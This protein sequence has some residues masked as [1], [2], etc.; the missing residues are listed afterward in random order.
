MPKQVLEN[1]KD[2]KNKDSSLQHP[3]WL[4]QPS[5]SLESKKRFISRHTGEAHNSAENSLTRDVLN[6]THLESGP[7]TQKKASQ[8]KSG[9]QRLAKQ[10]M[11]L[12]QAKYHG[13]LLSQVPRVIENTWVNSTN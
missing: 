5:G 9:N 8:V 13:N 4:W 10:K 3:P 2:G 11:Q 1:A 12:S 6:P 7:S